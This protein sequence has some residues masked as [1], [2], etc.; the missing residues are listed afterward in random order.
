MARW[1]GLRATSRPAVTREHIC[2]TRRWRANVYKNTLTSLFLITAFTLLCYPLS[3]ISIRT[4][5]DVFG[6]ECCYN[7]RVTA[8]TT[9]TVSDPEPAWHEQPISFLTGENIISCNNVPLSRDNSFC[10]IGLEGNRATHSAIYSHVDCPILA[11]SKALGSIGGYG[12]LPYYGWG[13]ESI[14]WEPC[15]CEDPT[16]GDF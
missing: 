14:C 4:T 13:A 2:L 5:A 16:L 15:N 3:G 8:Y 6:P 1:A 12:Q 9:V 7:T 11:R 10:C